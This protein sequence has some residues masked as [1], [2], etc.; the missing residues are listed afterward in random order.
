MKRYEKLMLLGFSIFIITGCAPVKVGK[1]YFSGQTKPTATQHLIVQAEKTQ[2]ELFTFLE[3]VGYDLQCADLRDVDFAKVMTNELDWEIT[4]DTRTL[5]PDN[6]KDGFDPKELLETSKQPSFHLQ[7]LHEQG[8]T[9]RQ[10]GIGVIG[11]P[12]LLQHDELRDCVKMYKSNSKSYTATDVSTWGVSYMAGKQVGVAPDANIYYIADVPD[13]LMQNDQMVYD[14]SRYAD[15]IYE[16]LDVNATLSENEKIRILLLPI[17]DFNNQSQ[18]VEEVQAAIQEAIL[19]GMIILNDD[20]NQNIHYEALKRN[21]S[22]DVNDLTAYDP[23]HISSIDSINGYHEHTLFVPMGCKTL[24]SPIGEH[25]YV[26]FASY[27]GDMMNYYLAGVF[28]LA[29]QVNPD[30]TKREIETL[31]YHTGINMNIEDHDPIPMLDPL[32]LIQYLQNT[33]TK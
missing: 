29:L 18:G 13:T 7:Q 17:Y 15:D 25:D 8:I 28:A 16:L 12:I 1:G 6:V 30:L 4:Y 21:T 10:V 31:L 27:G 5:W 24:A 11:Q 23:N 22:L 9:G 33:K 2:A 14:I 3:S 32:S 19:Q 26:Y 20:E